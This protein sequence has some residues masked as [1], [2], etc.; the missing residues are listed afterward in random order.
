MKTVKNIDKIVKKIKIKNKA[1]NKAVLKKNKMSV[2]IP[3]YKAP[4]V[5][6]DENRFFTGEFNKEKRSLFFS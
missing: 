2:Y 1:V 6:G 5:L 3:E 4:S